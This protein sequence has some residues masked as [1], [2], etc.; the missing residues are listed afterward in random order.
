MGEI[1]GRFERIGRFLRVEALP[2]AGPD[3]ARQFV[4]VTNDGDALGFVTWHARWRCYEFCPC[5]DTGFS[6]D[7]LRDL[8]AFVRRETDARRAAKMGGFK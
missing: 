5:A 6:W 7:C 4:V 1:I 3:A 2:L 8:S